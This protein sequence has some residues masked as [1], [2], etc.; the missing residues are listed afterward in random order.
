MGFPGSSAGKESACNVGDLGSIPGLGLLIPVFWPREFHGLC[1]P[2][3]HKE[4]DIPEQL[5]LALMSHG[6][7]EEEVR[8][9]VGLI[10]KRKEP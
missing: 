1:S 10:I 6:K 8:E 5:P 9:R 2:W 7:S 4:L 3:S